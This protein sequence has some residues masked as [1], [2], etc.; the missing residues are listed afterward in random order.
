M[1]FGILSG[2]I[3]PLAVAGGWAAGAFM[4]RRLVRREIDILR[5][6]LNG[7]RAGAPPLDAAQARAETPPPAPAVAP[8]A[9]VPEQEEE[10]SAETLSILAAAVAAYMGKRARVRG[11]RLLRT[12]PQA[13]PWAQQGQIGRASCRERV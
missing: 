7:S 3:V 6:E 11:A 13:S 4:A 10:V 8:P 5:A 1:R 12:G 2:L 9:P